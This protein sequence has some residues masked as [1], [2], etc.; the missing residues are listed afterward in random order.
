MEAVE[1]A[2]GEGDGTTAIEVRGKTREGRDDG[3]ESLMDL[4]SG[5]AYNGASEGKRSGM[6][7]LAEAVKKAG[8]KGKK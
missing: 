4:I 2:E 6:E 5:G 8:K 1:E 7:A 3:G